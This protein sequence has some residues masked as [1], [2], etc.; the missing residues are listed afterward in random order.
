MEARLQEKEHYQASFAL[1][2][3]S[4]QLIDHSFFTSSDTEV[5]NTVFVLCKF[6]Q[7]WMSAQS[8]VA[9]FMSYLDLQNDCSEE[10]PSSHKWK[11]FGVTSFIYPENLKKSK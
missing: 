1:R 9:Q 7:H 2:S 6:Q 8:M 5:D 10:S 4:T 3:A 11:W